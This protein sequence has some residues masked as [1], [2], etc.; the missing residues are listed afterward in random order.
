MQRGSVIYINKTQSSI[1][2]HYR[3]PMLQR[4]TLKFHYTKYAQPRRCNWWVYIMIYY[5]TCVLNCAGALRVSPGISL[6]IP[7]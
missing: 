4:S 3:R 6:R 7:L 5:A 2:Q 1:T